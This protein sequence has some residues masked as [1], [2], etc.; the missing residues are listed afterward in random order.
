MLPMWIYPMGNQTVGLETQCG[1]PISIYIAV[2][3]IREGTV[4]GG[5]NR[6]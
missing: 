4:G 6:R 5:V 1:I 3:T 2:D